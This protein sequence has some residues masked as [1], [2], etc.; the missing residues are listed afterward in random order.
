MSKYL[1]ISLFFLFATINFSQSNN[2]DDFY[3][4][5]VINYFDGCKKN[6]RVRSP[7]GNIVKCEENIPAISKA[8]ILEK[9]KNFAEVLFIKQMIPTHCTNAKK[10]FFFENAREPVVY[11][12][13]IPST[14]FDYMLFDGIYKKT[15]DVDLPEKSLNIDCIYIDAEGKEFI[16]KTSNWI[17]EEKTVPHKSSP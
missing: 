17:N 14:Y 10:L 5:E 9:E 7:E 4:L 11:K 13:H 3:K 12:T 15:Y 1:L 6:E 16:G 8:Y 2:F